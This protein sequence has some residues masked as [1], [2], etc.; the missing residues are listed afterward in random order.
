[1][2]GGGEEVG[3]EGEEEADEGEDNQ[4]DPFEFLVDTQIDEDVGVEAAEDGE[5]EDVDEVDEDILFC[6]WSCLVLFL[7]L[8]LGSWDSLFSDFLSGEVD[9]INLIF[10]DFGD[11]IEGVDGAVAEMFGGGLIVF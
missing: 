5:P 8:G 11:G 3:E 2:P 4:H 9:N 7:E 1:M 10:A 6:S